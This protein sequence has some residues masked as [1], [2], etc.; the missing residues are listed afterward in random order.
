M[1]NIFHQSFFVLRFRYFFKIKSFVR[2]TYYR[3]FGMKIGNQTKLPSIR[4]TWPHQVSI[5]NNC[6]LERG[7]FFKY[8]GIWTKGPSICIGN[9]VFIGANC[10]FNISEKITIGC[11]SMIASGCKFIDH[12]HSTAAILKENRGRD[13]HKEV[14]I[15]YDAWLGFNVIVLMGVEIG[16]SAII[17]A[18]SVVTKSVPA[19]EI[20]AGVPAKKIG[21]RS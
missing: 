4:I 16:A 6:V 8:D 5:G 2:K 19:N 7:I 18:G 9:N 20:W 11:E 10:E 12:N 17:A 13:V 14:K 1:Y 3:A 21:I 15:G